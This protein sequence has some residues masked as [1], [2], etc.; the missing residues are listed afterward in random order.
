MPSCDGRICWGCKP[1]TRLVLGEGGAHCC[2]WGRRRAAPSSAVHAACST[3]C[4]MASNSATAMDHDS[5]PVGDLAAAYWDR[6]APIVSGWPSESACTRCGA[7]GPHALPGSK[8]TRA[9]GSTGVRTAHADRERPQCAPRLSRSA[10][11]HACRRNQ[12]LV[13]CTSYTVGPWEARGPEADMRMSRQQLFKRC[14]AAACAARHTRPACRNMRPLTAA[15]AAGG[16]EGSTSGAGGRTVAGVR[17]HAGG[18]G[19]A[20]HDARAM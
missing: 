12:A 18:A 8:H 2:M 11:T 16:V 9:P 1:Q 13:R 6:D 3:A 4:V 7:V 17:V 14:K 20:R 10:A 5:G 15:A 19:V